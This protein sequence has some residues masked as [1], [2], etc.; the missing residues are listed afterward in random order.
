MRAA[1]FHWV[2]FSACS[3]PRPKLGPLPGGP[4][5][6]TER[7]PCVEPV[8]SQRQILQSEASLKATQDCHDGPVH[9]IRVQLLT[10]APASHTTQSTCLPKAT[11]RNSTMFGLRPRRSSQNAGRACDTSAGSRPSQTRRPRHV[12]AHPANAATLLC[13]LTGWAFNATSA[14]EDVTMA[15][16]VGGGPVCKTRDAP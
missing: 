16:A 5:T 8:P 9:S 10:D 14:Y 6:P 11:S 7:G 13:Q 12:L 2:S 3:P 4:N 15:H 1:P